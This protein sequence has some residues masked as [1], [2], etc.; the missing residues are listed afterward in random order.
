MI[1]GAVRGQD[2]TGIFQ[3]T[4]RGI[5]A[6]K[7]VQSGGLYAEGTEADKYIS[8]VDS[9]L[10]TV[11][12]HR[13]ATSG[14]IK[15]ENAH[16][17]S[18]GT[19]GNMVTGVHNGSLL[20][21]TKVDG[22]EGHSVDSS[23]ALRMIANEK[24]DAFESFKG[25]YSF[26]WFDH[27]ISSKQDVLYFARN[28]ER[29]MHFA[30]I[31]DT[32]TMIFGSEPGMLHWLAVRNGLRIEDDKIYETEVDTMYAFNLDNPRVFTRLKLPSVKY[33]NFKNIAAT[34]SASKYNNYDYWNGKNHG[35]WGRWGD[36][37]TE[38][39]SGLRSAVTKA[40]AS[41]STDAIE[42]SMPEME[43]SVRDLGDL[44]SFKLAMDGVTIAEEELAVHLDIM[45]VDVEV[46]FTSYEPTT[47][48]LRGRYM[49]PVSND[50][51]LPIW[52]HM[53]DEVI[54]RDIDKGT[55]DFLQRYDRQHVRICGA[56]VNSSNPDCIDIFVN[57]VAIK[58]NNKVHT[59]TV[60]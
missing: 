27:G 35:S 1:A 4:K 26:V 6:D 49:Y 58:N 30:Y 36:T 54:I 50:Q 33:S 39:L 40:L 9:S 8:D 53:I 14:T 11:V 37:Q 41:S 19:D 25:A 57:S 21:W 24:L 29:P 23:W 13:A 46:E 60:H 17:F 28:K 51:S 7:S 32:Q 56:Q 47:K 2:S 59:S 3:V 31:K 48:T 16:P 45:N 34:S 10:A 52:D 55:W 44:D 15:K 43:T 38:F 22:H 20:D 18:E 42:G 5:F 12:H